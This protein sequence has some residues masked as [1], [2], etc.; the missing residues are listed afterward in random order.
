VFELSRRATENSDPESLQA[1]HRRLWAADVTLEQRHFFYWQLLVRHSH[2]AHGATLSPAAVYR[3]LV[4]EARSMLDVQTRWI[5]PA[6]RD[7]DAIVVI[8]NQLLGPQHAPT[9]D[10]LDYCYLLQARL[11]KQVLLI[12]TADMPWSAPMPYYAPVQFNYAPEYSHVPTLRV[13]GESIDFYQC[14]KPMP[15]ALETSRVVRMAI[16]RKPSL[17]LSLGH[18][19]VAADLCADFVTVATMPF[20][21]DLPRALS[22]VYVLPRRRREDDA[23]FMDEWGI[24]AE[25]IVETEYTF[26]LPDR[27]ASMTRPDLGVPASAYVIAIVGNRLDEEITTGVATELV[28]L[29]TRVPEAFLLFMGRFGTYPGITAEHPVLASRSAFVGHQRDI[30]AVYE[31]CDAYYNPPRYGGGSSAAFALGMGLPVITGAGGDV[32]NIAGPRFV[33]GSIESKIAFVA[34][35][36]TLAGHRR[37]WAVAARSRFAQ[38]SDREAMLRA[39]DD[40]VTARAAIRRRAL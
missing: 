16:G 30:L 9:A 40:G 12:N 24:T 28:T 25:R 3:S 38:I 21:T 7:R 33:H 11:K 17:V 8:T 20:G 5:D 10:C 34:Q 26:R 15:N 27:T 32:S 13:R 18:S 31:C 22:N 6:D 1:L 19:N 14:R 36:A 4:A 37:E 29:L 39:I 35:A 23:A 2:L